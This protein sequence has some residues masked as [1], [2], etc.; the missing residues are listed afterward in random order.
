MFADLNGDGDARDRHERSR[1]L[2]L[3]TLKTE[4]SGGDPDDG[5][6]RGESIPAHLRIGIYHDDAY[7]CPGPTGC[8]VHFDN[9]QV[10]DLAD[11]E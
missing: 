8:A 11:A 7:D 6:K 4:T 2:E 1:R 9:V 3:A 5:I 10:V